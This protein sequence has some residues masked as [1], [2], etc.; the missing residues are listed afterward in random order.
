M[1]V[2]DKRGYCLKNVSCLGGGGGK[3]HFD[4]LLEWSCP[5]NIVDVMNNVFLYGLVLCFSIKTAV[6]SGVDRL[7]P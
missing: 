2:C 6:V 7:S 3:L 4:L 1:A 5:R